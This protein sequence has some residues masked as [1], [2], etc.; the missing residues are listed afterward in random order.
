M[1][2]APP[3]R[4][5]A[6]SPSASF[7]A[8]GS[9]LG[10]DTEAQSAL[11]LE[12]VAEPEIIDARSTHEPT[13]TSATPAGP[14]ILT[15]EEDLKFWITDFGSFPGT[16]LRYCG[17]E[18]A[19]KDLFTPGD[20]MIVFHKMNHA[21]DNSPTVKGL[22]SVEDNTKF[23]WIHLPDNNVQ[24]VQKVLLNLRAHLT[25]ESVADGSRSSSFST[26][27]FFE[28]HT[29]SFGKS[30]LHARYMRPLCQRWISKDNTQTEMVLMMPY[31][32]HEKIQSYAAM[33]DLVELSQNGENLPSTASSRDKLFYSHLAKSGRLQIRRSLD[34]AFYWTL[35]DTRRRDEDQVIDRYAKEH[36]GQSAEQRSLLMVDQLWLWLLNEDKN[37]SMNSIPCSI[38]CAY[39]MVHRNRGNLLPTHLESRGSHSRRHDRSSTKG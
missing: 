27:E 15:G 10:G 28:E 18:F 1:A 35:K 7:S 4:P 29:N 36:L 9:H 16:G 3:Q 17:E 13:T 33:R 37:D 38:A 23:R 8:I 32:H 25:N 5:E 11:R 21:W 19:L 6:A 30:H 34:Q 26:P 14:E 24:W 2:S 12:D 20:P 39:Y 22:K 31:V